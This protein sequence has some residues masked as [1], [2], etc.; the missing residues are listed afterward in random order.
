MY[1][2][3]EKISEYDGTTLKEILYEI[4]D[5]SFEA[6]KEKQDFYDLVKH[7]LHPNQQHRICPQK[8]LE[9]RFFLETIFSK[10]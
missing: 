1:D 2:E 6:E 10:L 8:A 7:M 3:P 4:D 5:D 9:H